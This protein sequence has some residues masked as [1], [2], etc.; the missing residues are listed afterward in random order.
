VLVCSAALANGDHRGM[1][2]YV[3]TTG[4]CVTNC[5]MAEVGVAKRSS[6]VGVV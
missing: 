5:R 3:T 2:R 6:K 1:T 4:G